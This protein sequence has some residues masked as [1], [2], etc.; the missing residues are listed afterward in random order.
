MSYIS[1]S[2]VNTV[3]RF[4]LWLHLRHVLQVL[5]ESQ[6]D[7]IFGDDA[8][9]LVSAEGKPLWFTSVCST[10][11]KERREKLANTGRW[12]IS[13]DQLVSK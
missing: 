5:D 2:M 6:L 7:F 12:E 9:H 13:P 1:S 11:D 10:Q 8:Q 4:V 3:F